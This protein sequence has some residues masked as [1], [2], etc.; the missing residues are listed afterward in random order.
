MQPISRAKVD[1]LTRLFMLQMRREYA[2][3]NPGG[4]PRPGNIEDYPAAHQTAIRKAIEQVAIAAAPER[5]A[6][7]QAWLQTRQSEA[8]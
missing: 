8:S 2:A 3:I 4:D 1:Y 5:E 6:Q 7:F